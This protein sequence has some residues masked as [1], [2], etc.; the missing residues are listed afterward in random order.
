MATG[1]PFH[2]FS[3]GP[4]NVGRGVFQPDPHSQCLY[5]CRGGFFNTA[6][7]D[8]DARSARIRVIWHP[9]IV[10]ETSTKVKQGKG[11]ETKTARAIARA[12]F[13]AY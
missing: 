5:L 7:E 9:Y 4:L 6:R 13:V 3:D 2:L 8:D 12:G 11:P 10:G 1:V